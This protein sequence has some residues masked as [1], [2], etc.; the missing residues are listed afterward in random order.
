VDRIDLGEV[1]KGFLYDY[2]NAIAQ[3]DTLALPALN[4]YNFVPTTDIEEIH[5]NM[6]QIDYQLKFTTDSLTVEQQAYVEYVACLDM[7]YYGPGVLTARVILDIDEPQCDANKSSNRSKKH[8]KKLTKRP[9]TDIQNTI[10]SLVKVYPNP[11]Q[12]NDLWFEFYDESTLDSDGG[13]NYQ[14]IDFSGRIVLQGSLNTKANHTFSI[15]LKAVA[16]GVYILQIRDQKGNNIANEKVV[17][18]H[19]N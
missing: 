8:N 3:A 10:N 18:N 1:N 17:V 16:Q 5:Y 9:E 15:P 4:S 12:G 2:N 7:F 11:T 6:L 19:K 14:L 13:I